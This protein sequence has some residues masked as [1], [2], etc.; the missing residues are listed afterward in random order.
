VRR[1]SLY[2]TT[3]RPLGRHL[4]PPPQTKKKKTPPPHPAPPQRW[5]KKNPAG[6][7]SRC[8]GTVNSRQRSSQRLR[9]INTPFARR[10]TP[11]IRSPQ[12]AEQSIGTK[13]Q[14]PPRRGELFRGR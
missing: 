4:P 2:P 3:E 8:R 11:L 6:P 5:E 10:H 1:A 9:W 13:R 12:C 7:W 14:C